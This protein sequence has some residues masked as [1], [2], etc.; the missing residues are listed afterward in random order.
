MTAVSQVPA[1]LWLLAAPMTAALITLIGKLLPGR[2]TALPAFLCW[3]G[4]TAWGLW[5]AAPAALAGSSLLYAFGGWEEP[6]GI[7]IELNPVSWAAVLL[8][9]LI[10]TAVW[11]ASHR[12]GG[13]GSVFFLIFYL[14][15]FAL[16]GVL[17]S[18]DLFNL[19]IWFELLSLS[20]FLLVG[21]DQTPAAMLAAFRYLLISTVSILGFLVGLWI[22]YAF[23]GTPSFSVIESCL[24]AVRAKGPVE[25]GLPPLH[26]I[27][28]LRTTAAVILIMTGMLTRS[29][30]VPFHGWL[31]P[32]HSSAPYPASALLSGFVI[33]VPVFAL[34]HFSDSLPQLPLT[35]LLLWIGVCS[36]IF[37]SIAAV[38][39]MDAKK[40]LA[41]SSIGHMGFIMSAFAAAGPHGKTAALLYISM[42]GLSKALLFLTVGLITSESGSRNVY[43]LR[44]AGRRFPA[45]ALFYWIAALTLMGFPFSGGYYAKVAVTTTVSSPAA[46][47]LLT[48]AGAATDLAL[49]KIGLI[50]FGRPPAYG[51]SGGRVPPK[52]SYPARSASLLGMGLLAAACAALAFFPDRLLHLAESLAGNETVPAGMVSTYFLVA[53]GKTSNLLKT[54]AAFL[55]GAAGLFIFRFQPVKTFSDRIS[56]LRLGTD[57]TVRL[58]IIGILIFLV[59]GAFRI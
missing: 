41:Y 33:K 24:A 55:I 23:C 15:L 59:S 11:L 4:G 5:Q 57:G 45:A 37:G 51:G 26:V 36:A 40:I 21:Y 31:P 32:A 49:F 29:A 9:L 12:Y 22:L 42:H 6:A 18:R 17:C 53:A 47:W 10:G 16:Q 50:F 30:V 25:G 13:I 19:F 14:G 46:Q 3:S 27:H 28:N 1:V 20:V 8:V 38:F 7:V 56:A 43:L 35:G 39:Q 52:I 54:S 44:G 48:A 2:W 34:W 58:L